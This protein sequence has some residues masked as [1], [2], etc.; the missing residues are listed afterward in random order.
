MHIDQVY[1]VFPMH[2]ASNNNKNSKGK[3]I[4]I[5]IA[6]VCPLNGKVNRWPN[7]SA[8]WH[9]HT[10]I[11]RREKIFHFCYNWIVHYLQL[12]LFALTFK[13][14]HKK[15]KFTHLVIEWIHLPNQSFS[16]SDITLLFR[17]G[18]GGTM[19]TF[20]SIRRLDSM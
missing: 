8:Y 2:D 18:L 17:G 20:Q 19:I 14:S 9:T 13:W 3:M 15:I 10:H 4:S 7:L 12:K 16:S 6:L 5:S 11:L 1:F